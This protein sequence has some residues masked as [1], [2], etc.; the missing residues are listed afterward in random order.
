VTNIAFADTRVQAVVPGDTTEFDADVR[1][2]L[3]STAAET[4]AEIE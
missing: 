4:P 2:G 1:R 3:I